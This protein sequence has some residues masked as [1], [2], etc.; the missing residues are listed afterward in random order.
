MDAEFKPYRSEKIVKHFKMSPWTTELSQTLRDGDFHTDLNTSADPPRVTLIHCREPDPTPGHGA[1]RV[2]RVS[3]LLTELR[4][5]GA[6]DALMFLLSDT[7][8]M[9]DERADGAWSGVMASESSIR[10]HPATL[11]AAK[12]RGSFFP[13]ALNAN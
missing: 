1:L 7:V 9:V 11:R 10:F 8:E 4:Q 13:A 3:E 5:R 2:A 12:R 6:E